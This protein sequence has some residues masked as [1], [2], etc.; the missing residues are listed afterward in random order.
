VLSLKHR[1]MLEFLSR[2][3]SCQHRSPAARSTLGL[4]RRFGLFQALLQRCPRGDW[5]GVF[6][7]RPVRSELSGG[8]LTLARLRTVSVCAFEAL[9]VV[10]LNGSHSTKDY[11]PCSDRSA[12]TPRS[13]RY[14]I[15]LRLARWHRRSVEPLSNFRSSYTV[16]KCIQRLLAI[17]RSLLASIAPTL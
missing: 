7:T 12:A 4:G 1:I 6:M 2:V 16:P 5:S 11:P 8:S 14:L 13:S 3:Q 15:C 9:G 10:G 17:L